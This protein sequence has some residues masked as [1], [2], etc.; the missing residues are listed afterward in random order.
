MKNYLTT[1]AQSVFRSFGVGR[2]YKE[3]K[4]LINTNAHKFFTQRLGRP[5]FIISK[6]F[7]VAFVSPRLY[8]LFAFI[9]VHSW[10]IFIAP[11]V[12]FKVGA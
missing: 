2:R 9:C 6:N 5:E 11:S 12:H 8:F 7:S 10:L 3:L 1:K 4:P